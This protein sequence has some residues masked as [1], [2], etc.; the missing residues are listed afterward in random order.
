MK[1]TIDLG[2]DD[3]TAAQQRLVGE[4]LGQADDRAFAAAMQKLCKAAIMEYIGMF[5]EKGMPSRADEVR[6]NRLYFLIRH[7]YESRIPPESEIFLVFQLTPSQSRTLLRNTRSRYRT[8]IGPQ[9]EA[10]AR[11]VVAGAQKNN[12]TARWKM[13]IDSEVLLE[14]LNLVI[15]RRGPTLKTVHLKGGSAGQYEAEEDTYLLLREE[16][17][18]D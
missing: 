13:V 2:D 9:V 18:I 12:D 6:Q 8:R 14:E 1:V 10:S 16:Y 17:G 15:A 4:A 11:A 5:V 3:F 7:Y